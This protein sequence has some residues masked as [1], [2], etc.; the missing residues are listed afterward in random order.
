M[1]TKWLSWCAAGS[2]TDVRGPPGL[3]SLGLELESVGSSLDR[4]V[5]VRFLNFILLSHMCGG[6]PQT[7]LAVGEK[8]HQKL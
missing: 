6:R 2:R 5:V 1:G 4:L 8:R 7:L 3:S